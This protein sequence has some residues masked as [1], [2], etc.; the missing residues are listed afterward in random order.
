[1]IDLN[2]MLVFA[3]V[4]QTGSFSAAA[5]DLEMPKSTVSRRVS[6]LEGRVGARLL[7]RT[8]RKLGLTDVGRV[9]YEYAARIVSE[10]EEAEQAVT[11]MQSSPRGLLRVSAPLSFAAVGP[12]VARFLEANPDVQL[13]LFCT[14]RQVHLVEEHFD[15]ALR[16]GN[17]ADSSLVAR[18]LGVIRSVLVAAPQYLSERGTPKAAREL[19]RHTCI[20]FGAGSAPNVWSLVPDAREAEGEEAGPQ[21]EEV[22]V[23][24]RFVVNDPETARNAAREGLG[25]AFLPEFVCTEDLAKRRL[26]RVLSG[27]CSAPTPLQAVYPSAR[28][29]SPKVVA[30]IEHLKSNFRL[31]N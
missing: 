26:R 22:R 24:P 23:T 12:V 19:T 17:L 2:E 13:E 10:A 11:R 14:D 5:R 21:R 7:Q 9:F 30:F 18:R 1:M 16:A 4:V 31:G 27:L 15:L 8:T 20:T 25:I 29:L 28:H 6:E 3:R